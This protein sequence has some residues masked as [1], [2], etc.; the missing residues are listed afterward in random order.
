MP[1][2]AAE[3]M[4]ETARRQLR[5]R[6]RLMRRRLRERNFLRDNLL[7]LSRFVSAP[8]QVGSIAPSSRSLGRA[9]AAELPSRF[10]ICVELGGGTGSLTRVMLAAGVPRDRLIVVERDPRLGAHLRNR[11]PGVKVVVGD[12]QELTTLLQHQG[13]ERV[14]AVISSLPLRSLPRTVG[15][16]ILAESFRVL[17]E[18][19]AY[20]QFTYGLI[21]PVPAATA[22]TLG[23]EGESRA[24]V[25]NNLP[26]ATVWRY[27]RKGSA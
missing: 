9:M 27:R 25:W 5:V 18:G 6:A 16:R 13:I 14:D 8:K 15:D 2:S 22:D 17:A 12:A 7:F 26:P 23:I 1:G 11:F 21:P 3:T 10:D 20:V 24:K 4:A 19:G